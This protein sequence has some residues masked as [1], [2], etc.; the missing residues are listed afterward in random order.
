MYEGMCACTCMYDQSMF[1]FVCVDVYM[2]VCM[3]VRMYV[4]VSRGMY[5][6]MYVRRSVLRWG[7]EC[8]KTLSHSLSLFLKLLCDI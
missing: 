6:C 2:Y 4:C 3:Y 1:V 5:V 8:L 7:S